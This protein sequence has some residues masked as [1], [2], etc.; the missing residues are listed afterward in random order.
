[1]KFGVN[2]LLFT[3]TFLESDLPLL[4]YCRTLGFDTIELSPIEPG[5]FPAA[6][7]KQLAASLGMTVN[8]NFAL[9]ESAN[10]VSPDPSIRA[11]SVDLSRRIVDLCNEAG[12]TIYCGSNYCSWRYFTGQRR[13]DDE[14]AWGVESMR[15]VGEYAQGQSDLVIALETLNRFESY[16]LNTA[17]DANRF[18]D[19]VGLP[20][21]KVHL[22]TFHMMY[23]EDDIGAAIRSSGDRLAYFHACGSQRGIPGRDLVPWQT[24]FEALRDVSYS[25][26]IT[27]ESFNPHQRIAPLAAIWR[28]FADSPEQLATEGLKFIQ[29][30]YERIYAPGAASTEMR[31]SEEVAVSP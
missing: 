8:V 21:V 15:A 6:K 4:E 26:C 1:M 24:T 2:S 5:R 31:P 22:D 9:P 17:A 3:D 27:I 10:P 19:D 14:W 12:A 11:K 28:D 7:V 23:E 16:F 20:N 13:S 29:Q 18:V 25:F 30:Q